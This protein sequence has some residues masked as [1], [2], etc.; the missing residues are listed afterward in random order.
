MTDLF[1]YFVTSLVD[2]KCQKAFEEL[3]QPIQRST[4][5]SS[6]ESA[7]IAYTDEV[8][9][10]SC[11]TASSGF[12]NDN[13]PKKSSQASKLAVVSPP[14]SYPVPSNSHKPSQTPSNI[15]I[16]SSESGNLRPRHNTEPNLAAS[17]QSTLSIA[18]ADLLQSTNS[19]SAA[20]ILGK[21]G[22]GVVYYGYWKHTAVAVKVP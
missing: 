6:I 3:E 5:K 2:A 22:Y 14:I 19:F 15:Q 1:V 10:S 16:A 4:A 7:N 20:N 13:S 8:S 9:S 21:G 11:F 17:L 18:F 12:Q